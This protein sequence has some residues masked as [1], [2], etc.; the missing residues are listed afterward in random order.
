MLYAILR[1]GERML[2]DRI[3]I[4]DVLQSRSRKLKEKI[5]SLTPD[6]LLNASEPDLITWL[7]D[8]FRMEV[9]TLDESKIEMEHRERQFDVSRSPMRIMYGDAPSIPGTEVTFILPFAGDASFFEVS[10]QQAIHNL[11]GGGNQVVTNGEIRFTMQAQ[12]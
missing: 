9:P 12:I 10:P 6:Y 11:S 3:S 2:F 7:K 5:Q 1:A 4:F 8:E